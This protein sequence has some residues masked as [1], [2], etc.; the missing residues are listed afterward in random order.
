VGRTG[1]QNSEAR[2]RKTVDGRWWMACGGRRKTKGGRRGTTEPV[3]VVLDRESCRNGGALSV[4]FGLW[5]LRLQGPKPKRF[6]RTAFFGTVETAPFRQKNANHS[7]C[8]NPGGV[9]FAAAGSTLSGSR[10]FDRGTSDP[11]VSP[12]ATHVASPS[13]NAQQLVATVSALLTVGLC[14][15][16]EPT[17]NHRTIDSGYPLRHFPRRKDWVAPPRALL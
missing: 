12:T 17:V 10:G 14:R 8:R 5:P 7:D 4:F 11:W 1:I 3:P 6:L 15:W 9:Q 13:G 16:G 2:S